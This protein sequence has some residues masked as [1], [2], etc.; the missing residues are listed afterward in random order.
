MRQVVDLT[1]TIHKGLI[2]ELLG[3]KFVERMGYP[4]V[5]FREFEN[6]ENSN[7][8]V[9]VVSFFNHVGTHFETPGF[10]YQGRDLVQD[11]DIKDLY[12]V[13]AVTLDLTFK[14]AG[15][16]VTSKDLERNGQ[17][18]ERGDIVLLH[19]G[20][21]KILLDRGIPPMP[22]YPY[23]TGDAA[24]QLVKKNV[25]AVGMEA[26]SIESLKEVEEKGWIGRNAPPGNWPAHRTLL[27]NGIFVIENL[28][29]LDKIV[30]KR[31]KL[32]VMPAKFSTV[33]ASPAR[34]V[35]LLDE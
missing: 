17:R 15:E 19:C 12:E 20:L 10:Y 35:A 26:P 33:A 30:G 1:R 3:E 11:V 5:E 24:K 22:I 18:I 9:H 31:I 7:A 28:I 34:V 23:L 25:R 2:K 13:P 29:N 6:F 16:G 27:G 14:K 8:I 4:E 21:D 32:T